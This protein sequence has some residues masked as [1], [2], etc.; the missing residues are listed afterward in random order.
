MIELA[1]DNELSEIFSDQR[2]IHNIVNLENHEFNTIS[3]DKDDGERSIT[4]EVAPWSH[5]LF[6]TYTTVI[7][8]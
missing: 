6:C 8:R 5:Y 3:S 2:L 4:T 7:T 1:F